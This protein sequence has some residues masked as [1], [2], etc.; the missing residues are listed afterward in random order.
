VGAGG[1][2][3]KSAAT[4]SADQMV[5]RAC[6][7]VD[8]AAELLE[9]GRPH[10]PSRSGVWTGAGKADGQNAPVKKEGALANVNPSRLTWGLLSQRQFFDS[11]PRFVGIRSKCTDS[12]PPPSRRV[13]GERGLGRQTDGCGRLRTVGLRVLK[14]GQG[15]RH[16]G[17]ASLARLDLAQAPLDVLA[18][19]KGGRDDCVI[20]TLTS[21]HAQPHEQSMKDVFKDRS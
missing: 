21:A 11:G 14:D 20:P 3:G 16:L 12:T 6:V 18:G 19:R 1:E 13:D 2:G 10:L 4:V 5:H 8:L 9:D 17:G 7:Y 15:L